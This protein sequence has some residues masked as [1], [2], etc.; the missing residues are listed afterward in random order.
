[1]DKK[2]LLLKNIKYNFLMFSKI[3]DKTIY[4]LIKINITKHIGYFIKPKKARYLK[5]FVCYIPHRIHKH[6]YL[7][8]MILQ[9]FLFLQ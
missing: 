4:D 7:F 8:K 9:I 1:M 6:V 5:Y 2:K 3:I